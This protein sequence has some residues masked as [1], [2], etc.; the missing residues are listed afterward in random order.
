MHESKY[1]GV[2]INLSMKTSSDIVRQ[3]RKFYAQATNFIIS[4]VK[5]IL[6]KSF[7][8]NMYCCPIWFNSNIKLKTGYNSALRN[9]FNKKKRKKEAL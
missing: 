5:C 1:L 7:C 4:D 9:F 6:L 8:A 3:T 2:I